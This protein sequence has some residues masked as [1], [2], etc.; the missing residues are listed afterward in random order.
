VARP[1]ISLDPGAVRKL[2]ALGATVAEIADFLG[3]SRATLERNFAAEIDKGKAQLKF[4]LRRWQLRAAERGNAALLIFL[5]KA[6]L[7]QREQLTSDETDPLVIVTP[8]EHCQ[9]CNGATSGAE[10]RKVH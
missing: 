8:C 7:G 4:K 5:G 9:E 2:A 10:D 3:V 6:M 1:R